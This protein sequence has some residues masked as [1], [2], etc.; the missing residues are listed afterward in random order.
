[1]RCSNPRIIYRYYYIADQLSSSPR[2]DGEPWRRPGPRASSLLELLPLVVEEL[3]QLLL[4][5][6]QLRV[7]LDPE[8]LENRD[9]H[10]VE[11]DALALDVADRVGQVHAVHDV[12]RRGGSLEGLVV[13][14]DGRHQLVGEI[15]LLRDEGADLGVVQPDG[16]VLQHPGRDALLL[17]DLRDPLQE[18][19]VQGRDDDLA[20]IVENA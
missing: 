12:P 2:G 15:P 20:E 10:L 3:R 13:V 17:A 14:A 6:V 16:K 1:M 19:G 8:V 4:D 7:G 9:L 11:P 18:L 5:L